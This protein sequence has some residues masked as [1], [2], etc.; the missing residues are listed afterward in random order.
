MIG[1]ALCL[2]PDRRRATGESIA[3]EALN[4]ML[5]L[6]RPEDIRLV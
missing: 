3:V 6:G 2:H 1:D 5:E 4:R